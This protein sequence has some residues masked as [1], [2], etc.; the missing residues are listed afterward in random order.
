MTHALIPALAVAAVAVPAALAGPAAAATAPAPAPVTCAELLAAYAEAQDAFPI[1]E[2]IEDQTDPLRRAAYALTRRLDDM[3][4]ATL[5]APTPTTRAGFEALALAAA[6]YAEGDA[7]RSSWDGA[8]DIAVL[9][10]ALVL[11]TGAALPPTF[12]GFGDEPDY[13]AREAAL[14]AAPGRLPE[15]MALA[16]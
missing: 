16:A 1:V 5:D 12:L 10:R 6:I 9:A 8:R 15:G 14:R 2:R 4:R 3:L 11:V 7:E 13:R